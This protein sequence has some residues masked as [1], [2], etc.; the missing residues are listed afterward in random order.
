MIFLASLSTFISMR[1]FQKFQFV[2]G[3]TVG[4][5]KSYTS[6][7]LQIKIEYLLI[8][9]LFNQNG[10]VLVNFN[11]HQCLLQIQFIQ[12][13]NIKFCPSFLMEESFPHIQLKFLYQRPIII[14]LLLTIN[15]SKILLGIL[16]TL[17]GRFTLDAAQPIR[18]LLIYQ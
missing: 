3:N 16:F 17:L 7:I 13:I 12:H 15:K 14:D 5:R 1:Q 18:V 11:A 2:Y 4:S 8:I 10:F 9:F 6:N